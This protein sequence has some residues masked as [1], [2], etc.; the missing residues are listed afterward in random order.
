MADG[1]TGGII[2][3]EHFPNAYEGVPDTPR[4][5]DDDAPT[6]YDFL[7]ME[8]IAAEL[9]AGE[10]SRI[11][12]LVEREYTID[13]TSRA[14]WETRC[15]KAMKIAMQVAEI[16]QYPWPKAANVKFPLLTTAAI[17]FAARAYPAIVQGR[18][19]VKGQVL[20]NDDG[21]P[22][23]NP[24]DG[25]PLINEETGEPLW[26]VEPGAKRAKA[27]RIA[28]HMSWQ[29][30]DDMEEWD[31]E[32]DKL[33]HVLPILGCVFRKTWFDPSLGNNRSD[34]IM[35]GDLVVNYHAKHLKTTP[36][37]THVFPL[38][39]Y[40]ITER[41]RLGIY[42][43]ID[44]GRPRDADSTDDDAPHDFLEQHRAL[45]LD[46]DGYPE[47][48][49]VTVHKDTKQVV[50]IVARF[51]E[52]GIIENRDGKIAKIE[53]VHYFT[54]YTFLPSPDGGFYD[55]G[56]GTLLEP[57]N[58]AINGALNQLLDA[59]H[60]ANLQGGFIGRG[61]RIRGGNNRHRPGEWKPVDV[62]GG[63]VRDNIVPLPVKEPSLVLFNLLG[64]LIDAAKDITA[65]KDILTGDQGK[66][67][68]ATTTLAR[69]EQGLK[70]FTAI[71]KRIF[72]AEKQEFKKLA[73]LNR[74]YLE[75]ETYFAFHDEAEKI[76][77]EDYEDEE[78]D[79]VPVA[80]PGVVTD[81][82]RLAKAEFLLPFKD[83][84][85]FNPREIR[86]RL[87]DA[88]SV[89]EPDK[90][91]ITGSP[92]QDPAV[93][94]KA[95]RIDMDKRK[96]EIEERKVEREEEEGFWRI[97]KLKADAILSLARAEAEEIG[98]DLEIYKAELSALSSDV[99]ARNSTNGTGTDT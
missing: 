82:Q 80:D 5:Q 42:L 35:P 54:K 98:P 39:P 73:R 10:L 59:G 84:P 75:P 24:I 33:L 74:L 47:P 95:D 76:G 86:M 89:D 58:E 22:Q 93:L 67:E 27:D 36:R 99:K 64:L 55:M 71:W 7:E 18:N 19:V 87:L 13:K 14:D 81:M 3:T 49:I 26:Q 91:L 1:D 50:R 20:G 37:A 15:E 12:D 66:V 48:Y 60:L 11:G 63:T 40:E 90:L 46:K 61:L 92:P 53:P 21:K 56:F 41:M 51:D 9:P 17:Q 38:Y 77:P 70:V 83:D 43:D 65:T 29:L 45:D 6:V 4:K 72:R 25:E 8:N 23:I 57:M 69:L 30:T 16:K 52:D 44:L 32:T 88:V 78:L 85:F 79:V 97:V 28:R 34:M 96:I 62:Q 94:E 2:T 31:E 68:P